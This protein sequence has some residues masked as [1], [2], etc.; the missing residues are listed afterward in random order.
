MSDLL[1]YVCHERCAV[2]TAFGWPFVAPAST[3][4][5]LIVAFWHDM[6]AIQIANPVSCYHRSY[7]LYLHCLYFLLQLL[8][9]RCGVTALLFRNTLQ[10]LLDE[11]DYI[12]L[13]DIGVHAHM[14]SP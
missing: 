5:T 14:R 3:A 9:E 2:W 13:F 6:F 12:R 7:G 8:Q 4:R 1:F 10:F 11:V